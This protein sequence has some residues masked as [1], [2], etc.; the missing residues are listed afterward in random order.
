MSVADPASTRLITTS[1]GNQVLEVY[2]GLGQPGG[3]ASGA[4]QAAAPAGPPISDVSD[5]SKAFFMV[6][7]GGSG[8]RGGSTAEFGGD[9]GTGGNSGG[10]NC[11]NGTGTQGQPGTAPTPEVVNGQSLFRGGDGGDGGTGSGSVLIIANDL[12][13]DDLGQPVELV[14]IGTGEQGGPG[15]R[16][17]GRG[18]NGGNGGDGGDFCANCPLELYPAG[19]AGGG[20]ERGAGSKGGSGGHGGKG[21]TVFI[22]YGMVNGGNGWGPTFTG[23]QDAEDALIQSKDGAFGAS[24]MPGPFGLPGL[25]GSSQSVSSVVSNVCDDLC[26]DVE[27][28]EIPEIVTSTCQCPAVWDAFE[29]MDNYQ[30]GK[31]LY[32]YP[33]DFFTNRNA[34]YNSTSGPGGTPEYVI[35]GDDGDMQYIRLGSSRGDA[36]TSPKVQEVEVFKCNFNIEEKPAIWSNFTQNVR[37]AST[38]SA[39]TVSETNPGST[40]NGPGDSDYEVN[41]PSENFEAGFNGG[42][43]DP[44]FLF[45][46]FWANGAEFLRSEPCTVPGDVVPPPPAPDE[47]ANKDKVALEEVDASLASVFDGTLFNKKGNQEETFE[48]S[49]SSFDWYIQPVP[50]HGQFSLNV[51]VPEAFNTRLEIRDLTGRLVWSRDQVSVAEGSNQIKVSLPE[52]AHGVYIMSLINTPYGNQQLRFTVED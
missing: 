27:Y 17:Y 48:Q 7:N 37:N 2:G 1:G 29:R 32:D 41:G 40:G 26:C 31:Q 46:G 28:L 47:E 9:G 20:G 13:Y 25:D 49:I 16:G 45:E 42:I 30:A 50:N 52:T 15:T 22:Y 14:A 43:G 4:Q 23:P 8:G 33:G 12:A 51:Q 35:V 6:G 34:H 5:I 21:G 38:F 19:G 11:P 39:S 44:Y 24:G 36:C 3:P 18:G 10:A